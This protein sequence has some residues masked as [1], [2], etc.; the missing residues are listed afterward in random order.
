MA[1]RLIPIIA[2]ILIVT[3][4]SY[5]QRCPSTDI[6]EN[7]ET[8]K[9]VLSYLNDF[10]IPRDGSCSEAA[11]KKT[12]SLTCCLIWNKYEQ[13]KDNREASA[14]SAHLGGFAS[15]CE[16]SF[17]LFGGCRVR[18]WT[19]FET[20]VKQKVEETVKNCAVVFDLSKFVTIDSQYDASKVLSSPGSK[21]GKDA[22]ESAE[23]QN[24]STHALKFWPYHYW[25]WCRWVWRFFRC[26][27]IWF[28]YWW[29]I[30][31]YW[32]T[33]LWRCFC[34]WWWWFWW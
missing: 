15:P 31:Y 3:S 34:Y 19:E 29:I 1:R 16:D 33:F 8:S 24:V 10:R 7:T 23:L 28:K 32:W 17:G 18:N 14:L 22:A 20:T 2:V 5:A 13:V 26:W 25:W 6:K 9:D 11:L 21:I 12:A 4:E 30:R 27:P